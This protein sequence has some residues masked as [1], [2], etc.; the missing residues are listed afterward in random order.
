MCNLPVSVPSTWRCLLL[1]YLVL[2]PEDQCAQSNKDISDPLCQEAASSW[3]SVSRELWAPS[4]GG[5]QMGV[6][7]C[8]QEG[9]DRE[10]EGLKVIS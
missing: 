6:R 7:G 1:S 9:R 10:R 3:R 8:G 4:P 5:R 2:Y